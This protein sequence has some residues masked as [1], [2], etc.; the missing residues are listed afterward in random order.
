MH[1]APQDVLVDSY[2]EE[3]YWQDLLRVHRGQHQR[4]AGSPGDPHFVAMSGL[5]APSMA[6]TFNHPYPAPCMSPAPTPFLWAAV[7]AL[8]NA[9]YRSAE[10]MGVQI[11]YNTPVAGA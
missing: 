9:Y 6:L 10:Q 3:E 8:V 4:S 1:D 7:K 5:D 2:P 11:R